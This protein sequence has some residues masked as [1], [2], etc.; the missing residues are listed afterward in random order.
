MCIGNDV[1]NTTPSKK[2]L[3]TSI[4]S[5]GAYFSSTV[6]NPLGSPTSNISTWQLHVAAAMAN[7][8]ERVPGFW[9]P[10]L[11]VPA[12]FAILRTKKGV[13]EPRMEWMMIFVVGGTYCRYLSFKFRV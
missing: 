8:G 12:P 1:N 3:N 9:V 7:P 5:N 4:I 13:R 2:T 11:D 10:N 6:W